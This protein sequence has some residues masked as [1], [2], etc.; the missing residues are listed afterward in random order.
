ME[1]LTQNP[2]FA[3]GPQLKNSRKSRTVALVAFLLAGCTSNAVGPGPTSDL[4]IRVRTTGGIAGVDFTVLVDGASS[5][6]VGESCVAGCDFVSGETLAAVTESR[7]R[8]WAERL[9]EGGIVQ[10]NG[11]DYGSGCCDRFQATLEYIDGAQESSVQGTTD[12]MPQA[13]QDVVSEISQLL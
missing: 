3:V 2:H 11:R 8:E 12:L 6:V 10:E 4:Q 9:V 1:R 13:F 5:T 7:I